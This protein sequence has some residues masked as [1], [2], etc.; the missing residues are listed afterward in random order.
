MKA[1]LLCAC[2]VLLPGWLAYGDDRFESVPKAAQKFIEESDDA[3]LN[4]AAKTPIEKIRTAYDKKAEAIE[5][6]AQIMSLLRIDEGILDSEKTLE[7]IADEIRKNFC[8]EAN[9]AKLTNEFIK[10]ML[11]IFDRLQR[12]EGQWR[13]KIL[14]LDG[15]AHD[16]NRGV[17]GPSEKDYF[18]RDGFRGGSPLP[19]LHD[20]PKEPESTTPE[21]KD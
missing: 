10:S 1:L 6:Q 15:V 4:F 11:E 5:R 9:K 2:L 16:K 21:K 18:G 12:K 17:R 14:E 19:R 8:D 20:A 13:T 3:L 7:Q